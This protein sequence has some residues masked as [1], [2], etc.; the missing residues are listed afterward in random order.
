MNQSN[1]GLTPPFAFHPPLHVRQWLARHLFLAHYNPKWLA[2]NNQKLIT[3]FDI[4]RGGA[5]DWF[6]VC[7]QKLTGLLMIKE[8]TIIS[9]IFQLTMPQHAWV[10][11]VL[12]TS[13]VLGHNVS[14]ISS[15][16]SSQIEFWEPSF[17]F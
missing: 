10:F 3:P 1:R 2:V 9:T 6:L 14:N 5:V 11:H 8:L 13:V 17:V 7:L 12:P 4:Q 16:T 15:T